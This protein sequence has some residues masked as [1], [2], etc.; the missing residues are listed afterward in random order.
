M[1]TSTQW[2]LARETAERYEQIRVPT[3]LGPAARALVES[4]YS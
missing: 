2:Q 3:I 1:E 4:G